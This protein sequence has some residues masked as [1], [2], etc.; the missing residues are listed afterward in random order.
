LADNAL[1]DPV[2]K[3]GFLVLTPPFSDI[4]SNPDDVGRR[5][6]IANL[7]VA[8]CNLVENHLYKI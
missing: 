1:L 4:A 7:A 8:A 5:R 6:F 2:K 3:P